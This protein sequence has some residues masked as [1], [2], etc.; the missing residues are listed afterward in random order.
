[1]EAR[2][3][4][5]RSVSVQEQNRLIFLFP[6]GLYGLEEY[7]YYQLL[8]PDQTLPF[9]YLQAKEEDQIRLL[10]ADPFAFYPQYEFKLPDE[11]V[12][13]LGHPAPETVAVW[14]TVNA[15]DSLDKATVNLLAP[16]VL[17]TEK[18]LGKQVVLHNS[19]YEIKAPLFPQQKE[20]K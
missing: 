20:G 9:A 17:N 5:E 1:M 11:D 7:K 13:V 12:E 16:I 6:Q 19:G 14:V 15:R 2:K 8:I 3:E 18:G 4:M 10:L